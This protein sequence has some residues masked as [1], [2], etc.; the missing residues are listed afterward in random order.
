[1]PNF[2]GKVGLVEGVPQCWLALSPWPSWLR[3]SFTLIRFAI[4]SAF[5]GHIFAGLITLIIATFIVD[6]TF[7]VRV[8]SVIAF[9]IKALVAVCSFFFMY[10]FFCGIFF[11]CADRFW[12]CGLLVCPTWSAS[13]CNHPLWAFSWWLLTFNILLLHVN[14]GKH[15]LIEDNFPYDSDT[16]D[17]LKPDAMNF[18]TVSN[19]RYT[20][21]LAWSVSFLRRPM[22]FTNAL[23]PNAWIISIICRLSNPISN[24]DFL[25]R[26]W[27]GTRFIMTAACRIS[28]DQ[29]TL[30]G[31]LP[32][33]CIWIFPKESCWLSLSHRWIGMST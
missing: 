16:T 29:N 22:M 30:L 4:S 1:M 10:L 6:V 9:F 31:F 20:P 19:P 2:L 12:Y 27:L 23:H 13:V 7:I 14:A 21:D 32:W 33:S 24:E 28:C 25:S 15:S 26:P 11:E 5:P 17:V 3:F 8:I 18:L